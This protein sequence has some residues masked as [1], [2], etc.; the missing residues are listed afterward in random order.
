MHS[1]G[2]DGII[3]LRNFQNC[4]VGEVMIAFQPIRS[5]AF[6]N[7]KLLV[8]ERD[9]ISMIT[10]ENYIPLGPYPKIEQEVFASS[11]EVFAVAPVSP[12]PNVHPV[13]PQAMPKPKPPRLQIKK[14]VVRHSPLQQNR[15]LR[16]MTAMDSV[17]LSPTQM[18]LVPPPLKVTSQAKA[19]SY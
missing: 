9:N 17:K 8:N 3:K 5:M 7:D 6:L 4:L 15:Y 11:S 2:E 1:G 14:D 12:K 13:V 18:G 19:T 16:L 10:P